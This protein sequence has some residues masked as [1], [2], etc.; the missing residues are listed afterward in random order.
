MLVCADAQRDELSYEDLVKLRVV[1]DQYIH[2]VLTNRPL[3][4]EGCDLSRTFCGLCVSVCVCVCV[5][6]QEQLVVSSRDYT[7]E[8]ALSRRV[9]DWEDKIRPELSLQVNTPETI[10]SDPSGHV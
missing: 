10:C 6:V 4:S 7:Q 1:S 9:K 2:S 8:T 5:C 3:I